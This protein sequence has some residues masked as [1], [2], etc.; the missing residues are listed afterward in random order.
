MPL[1]YCHASPTSA[2]AIRTKAPCLNNDPHDG[3]PAVGLAPRTCSHLREHFIDYATL[4]P[5]PATV[6][7][8]GVAPVST[9]NMPC[10][11]TRTGSSWNQMPGSMWGLRYCGA[12]VGLRCVSVCVCVR[13]RVEAGMPVS[14]RAGGQ[15]SREVHACACVCMCVLKRLASA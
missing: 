1:K 13:A 2:R 4:A 9:S 14:M 6:I 12:S 5:H 8:A 7:P 11:F 15:A 10:I 3:A